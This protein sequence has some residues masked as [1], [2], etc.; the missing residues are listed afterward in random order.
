VDVLLV[1]EDLEGKGPSYA[2]ADS[3]VETRITGAKTLNQVLAE[4]AN[5]RP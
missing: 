1:R 2:L 3:G 5:Q 4:L